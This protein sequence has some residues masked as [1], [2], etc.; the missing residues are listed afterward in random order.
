MSYS[1]ILELSSLK[2]QAPRDAVKVR[3]HYEARGE[4]YDGAT[5][6]ASDRKVSETRE[7][8]LK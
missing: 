8:D 1:H 7:L 3:Y 2:A 6:Y 4:I 5:V